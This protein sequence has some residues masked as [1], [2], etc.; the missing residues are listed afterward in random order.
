MSMLK[1]NRKIFL[2][3]PKKVGG[4]RIGVGEKKKGTLQLKRA[5]LL[6]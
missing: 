2:I 4:K 5:L 6:I 3:E 1:G